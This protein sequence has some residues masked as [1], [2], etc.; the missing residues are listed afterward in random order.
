[1]AVCA[2]LCN[3]RMEC[4]SYGVNFNGTRRLVSQTALP[5]GACYMCTNMTTVLQSPH[6]RPT[7]SELYVG[8]THAEKLPAVKPCN[9]TGACLVCDDYTRKTEAEATMSLTAMAFFSKSCAFYVAGGSH[10]SDYTFTKT[11]HMTLYANEAHLHGAIN[12]SVPL[13]ISGTS[14]FTN[15]IHYTGPRLDIKGSLTSDDEVAVVIT[16]VTTN[17]TAQVLTAKRF[18]LA[19][20][21]VQGAITILKCGTYGDINATYGASAVILQ[22]L[23]NDKLDIAVSKCETIDLSK[24][25]NIYGQTYEI[26]FYHGDVSDMA[27]EDVRLVTMYAAAMSAALLVLMGLAFGDTV[28]K[29]FT[30][31]KAA[32]YKVS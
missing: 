23:A 16:E 7:C 12:A 21:H 19:A 18:A 11:R 1:M 3:A 30:T 20:A 25:L 27:A 2:A 10:K 29:M 8:T 28:Y 32:K 4:G 17:M 31:Q 5:S 13:T 26:I 15:R 9:E 6:A 22:N 14:V 24:L